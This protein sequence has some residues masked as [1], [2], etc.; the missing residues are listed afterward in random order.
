MGVFSTILQGARH[1]LL[2]VVN[3]YYEIWEL[4]HLDSKGSKEI[5]EECIQLNFH[6]S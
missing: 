1:E 3:K 2:V 5:Q 4:L 6:L